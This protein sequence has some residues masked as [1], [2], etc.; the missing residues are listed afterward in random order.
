MDN[1][2]LRSCNVCRQELPATTDNFYRAR[3]F[4]LGLAYTC[5]PCDKQRKRDNKTPP[6]VNRARVAKH[7][8]KNPDEFRA[9]AAARQK[10]FR[11]HNPDAAAAIRR[12]HLQAHPEKNQEWV[13]RYRARKI[14]ATVEPV[15]YSVIAER[16]ENVCHICGFDVDLTVGTYDPMARTF[17]HVIPLSR[18]GAH[19]MEN[20][21]VAHRLCNIRKNNRHVIRADEP[22]V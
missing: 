10:A 6:D 21:K 22:A 18:G 15:D 4:P 2:L 5:I 7:A 13:N 3:R 19:S 16:D 20:V 12:R 1:V 14:A 8:A 17:D 9:K 11:E